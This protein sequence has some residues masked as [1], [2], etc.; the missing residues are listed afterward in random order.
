MYAVH[1]QTALCDGCI[2]NRMYAHIITN[3][4]KRTCVKPSILHI[5]LLTYLSAAS[6]L[7]L[8]ALHTCHNA[9]SEGAC[10]ACSS[11]RISNLSQVYVLQLCLYAMTARG[12]ITI[13]I[14]AISAGVQQHTP[15]AVFGLSGTPSVWY[16]SYRAWQCYDVLV[17]SVIVS[18]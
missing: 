16:L 14:A 4:H 7:M 6:S 18:M 13:T 1:I 5:G 12:P 8:A 17:C 2:S 9:G 15:F 10:V 3:T 11:V